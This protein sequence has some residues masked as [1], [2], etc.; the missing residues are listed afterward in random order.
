MDTKMI[1]PAA[2]LVF[3]ADQSVSMP[4]AARII[5]THPDMAPCHLAAGR[6]AMTQLAFTGRSASVL[7]S[8]RLKGVCNVLNVA[9]AGLFFTLHQNGT[10]AAVLNL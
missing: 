8:L 10:V 2:Q 7:L 5:R 6:N 1:Q 9:L 3:A 4:D